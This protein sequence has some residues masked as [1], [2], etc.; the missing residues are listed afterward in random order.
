MKN[1]FIT[2]KAVLLFASFLLLTGVLSSFTTMEFLSSTKEMLN[3]TDT[4]LTETGTD[5]D[6]GTETGTGTNLEETG[7]T[8]TEVKCSVT[9]DCPLGVRKTSEGK[10]YECLGNSGTCKATDEKSCNALTPRCD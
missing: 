1:R 4:D 5:T 6:T 9:V 8:L 2:R 7:K 10:K 3:L